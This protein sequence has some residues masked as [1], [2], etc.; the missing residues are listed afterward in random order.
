MDNQRTSPVSDTRQS[1][2]DIRLL[3]SDIA[4]AENPL[5]FRLNTPPTHLPYRVRTLGHIHDNPDHSTLGTYFDDAMLLIIL[6]GKGT[7][8]L[9]TQTQPLHRGLVG[10]ILPDVVPGLVTA[11][12]DDPYEHLHC[13]FAGDEA[14]TTARRISEE[15]GSERFFEFDRWDEA[16]EVLRRGLSIWPG[17][18]GIRPTQNHRLRRVDAVLAE[19]L[20]CLD[21]ASATKPQPLGAQTLWEYMQ[22]K[23]SHPINLDQVAADFKVSKPHLCKVAK[24]ELGQSLGEAWAWL[25]IDWA[26]V[27]LGHQVMN[28]SQISHKV[29]YEDPLY[30]SRVFKAR[31]GMS[32]RQWRKQVQ[33]EKIQA[34]QTK[35]DRQ[36]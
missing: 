27:L 13:R 5:T 6:A 19:T 15:H 10:L 26:K 2:R 11:D 8:H 32:P 9:G 23:I 33:Y 34:I 4:E 28:I 1:L 31:A 14:L 20:A 7:Y 12:P 30:F 3:T 16:A 21:T 25:K 29:G 22:I 36:L 17:R 35:R 24:R 18:E